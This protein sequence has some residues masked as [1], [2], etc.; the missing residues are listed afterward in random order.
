MA[1]YKAIEQIARE[2]R[3]FNDV[4]ILQGGGTV[5]LLERFGL[6]INK[7]YPQVG[8]AETLSMLVNVPGAGRPLDLSRSLDGKLHYSKRQITVQATCLRPK[9]Q[10]DVLQ[11]ELEALLQGQWVWFRFKK[12][13]YFWRGFCTVS[14]QRKEHSAL[15]TLTAVCSPYNYNLTAYM[16]SAWLW[17]TFNFEKD[18]IYDVR[19]EVKNL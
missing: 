18:T 12:D 15:V 1:D 17:D 8:K 14:M 5:S 10:L 16:G 11:K 13:A 7:G 3:R 6:L 9:D 2:S 19:T 4:L